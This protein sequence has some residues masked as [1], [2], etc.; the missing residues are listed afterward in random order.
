MPVCKAEAHRALELL[1]DYYSRLDESEEKELKAAIERVIKIFKSRLFQ[2]LLDI[3]EFY[4]LTLMDD[5]KSNDIKVNEAKE[6]A[7]RWEVGQ[8]P[9][10]GPG[11]PP[12]EPNSINNSAAPASGQPVPHGIRVLPML[13]SQDAYPPAGSYQVKT[14]DMALNN[15]VADSTW[16]Y[17]EIILERGGSG[18]GFSIAGGIDNPHIG[19]DTSIYITKLI[20]GGAA[21][22]DKRLKVNDIITKVN[23]ISVVNVSHAVSVEA[24]KRAGN[25]VVLQIKR[26]KYAS[27]ARID[28][29]E[30]LLEVELF[31]GNKGLGFTIAG[32][33]GNQ[34][35][36]GDNG[37]YVTK[38]MD[39]GA[40]AA[41]GRISVGDR[42]VAVK[43]LP[44]GDF[45]LDNCTHEEAVNALKKCRE[46]VIL[47]VSKTETPYPSSPTIDQ[48][49]TRI[50]PM[51]PVA[52][53][54]ARSISDEEFN[55]PRQVTLT[56]SAA[57]LGFNIVGGEDGEGIFVSFILSGGPADVSR[58]VRRGDRILAVNG[59]DL[60]VATH[61]EAA[62]ALKR[63]GNVVQLTLFYRPDEYEK[64]EAKIHS[65]KNAIMSGS[66]I[67]MSE[68]RSLFVRALFDYDPSREDDIPSRGLA[69][70]FGDILFVTNASD[71]EWW[72]A[73][74]FDHT[75]NETEIGIIPS[76]SRWEKKARAR[77]RNVHWDSRGGSSKN[78]L[79]SKKSVASGKNRGGQFMKGK[80]TDETS[81]ASMETADSLANEVDQNSLRST[82]QD[83]QEGP[84]YSYELVQEVEIDYTRPVVILGPLK[85]RINDELISEYPDR[86]GSCVP[87]TTRPRRQFEVNGRDYHF[88]ES[89][90]AMEADIQNHK[91]I[92]AGQYNNNLYG[93]SVAS[94]KEVAERS[95]HCILDVSGNAIKRLEAARL[96]PI[97]IFLKPKSPAFIMSVND[98]MSDEQAEKSFNRAVRLEQD[99]L[100]YFT[101]IV[102]GEK[103]EDIY[104]K[105]KSVIKSHSK[106]RIWVS[107]NEMF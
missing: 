69:F 104:E 49:Q 78:S 9:F 90:S 50:E 46:K 33:I 47:V 86:F 72:Q 57:G 98:R 81:N 101:S 99:F 16:E 96:Y 87:H 95:K 11:R 18:L 83:L 19:T 36:P 44:G 66:M 12:P 20:P 102:D 2:A 39:G 84:I 91:F 59:A 53:Q 26:R 25:R 56:K 92:E 14:L 100:Q 79:R 29:N 8:G 89:R 105:V 45:V 6:M 60:T 10:A 35:I 103:F 77:D 55:V 63:A 74:R 67:R 54:P 31:K 1:E 62:M 70:S 42:L 41:D 34:H 30:E 61:E 5:G 27:T 38:V 76:K 82:G 107:A 37:I 94:V 13:K 75:G 23:D 58:Q 32:G 40:A 24:L 80:E 7:S 43:N 88:V 68:K 85:D 51:Q 93:T 73:K 97:A 65:L 3:Q 28:Q 21:S 22:N 15:Q 4:E 52:H 64:F 48:M 17:D 71:E 106:T